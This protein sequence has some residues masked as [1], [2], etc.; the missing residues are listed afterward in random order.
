MENINWDMVKA[1]TGILS[2]A[3]ATIGVLILTAAKSI[4]ITKKDNDSTLALIKRLSDDIDNKLYKDGETLFLLRVEY[5]RDMVTT[6]E[7]C[8]IEHTKLKLEIEKIR[9][10]LVPRPEW[11]YSK[12]GRERRTSENIKIISGEIQKV[13]ESINNMRKENSMTSKALGN[14][15]GSFKTYLELEKKKL[16]DI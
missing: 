9:A 12:E 5:K 6:R 14:L 11:V 2:F 16:H 10:D 1:M 15:T 8:A 13:Y 3:M 7:H 4:F